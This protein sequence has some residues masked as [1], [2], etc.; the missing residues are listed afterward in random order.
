MTGPA[1]PSR[2]LD[3]VIPCFD[4]EELLPLTVPRIRA[5]LDALIADPG[6]ALDSWRLI[7][8]DDG[9]DDATWSLIAGFAAD[10]AIVGVKL[11]R[12]FGHQLAM[13]AGLTHAAEPGGGDVV[14]TMDA[15]LQDDLAAIDAMVR[16]H[17]GG[18]D[19]AL[20]VRSDRSSDSA[21]KSG[22]A[23][24]YYR[25]LRWM[26]VRVIE[27]HADYRLMSRRALEAL[28]AHREVNLFLRGLIPQLGFQV[29]LIPYARQARVAGTTKY[30]LRKMLRLAVD[31]ITSFTVTPLRLI[32]VSGIAICALSFLT[33]LIFLI[34]YVVESDAMVPGWASIALPILFLGGMQLLAIGVLGEYVGK[35]YLEV[36]ARP[37]FLVER[38]E[39][40][41]PPI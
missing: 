31:G 9:S 38:V 21:G 11:S 8:V 16:A 37:R 39:G 18:A 6:N 40:E 24:L 12:N 15:D 14:L 4:E 33:A 1:A 27:D 7:L 19:L 36:K 30:S 35:I 22:S 2:S 41:D 20:G 10:P 26:G 13:L 29:A 25:L 23:R 3:V 17:E 34:L 5:H 32:A 28:L